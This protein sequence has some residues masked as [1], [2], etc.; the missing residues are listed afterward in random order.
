MRDAF[1]DGVVMYLDCINEN[2]QPMV[3][4]YSFIRYYH[5]GDC[6]KSACAL[7]VS[8]LKSPYEFIIF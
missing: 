5:S 2:V 6:I 7:S 8:F 3:L 4:Y 1:G